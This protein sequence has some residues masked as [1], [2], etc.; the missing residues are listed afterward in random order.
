M[1]GPADT[2][3]VHYNHKSILQLR[4]QVSVTPS[5]DGW[6]VMV[7]V[8]KVGVVET[9]WCQ[10]ARSRRWVVE[11]CLFTMHTGAGWAW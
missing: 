1:S 10:P 3:V 6:P 11:V 8:L 5:R 9:L 7:G 4:P 2:D